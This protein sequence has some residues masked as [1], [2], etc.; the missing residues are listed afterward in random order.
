MN[1]FL[2]GAAAA[3]TLLSVNAANAQTS[4]QSGPAATSNEKMAPAKA[5][6]K[7]AP[8]T[9]G[10]SADTRSDTSAKAQYDA[11]PT[12]GTNVNQA[13]PEGDSGVKANDHAATPKMPPN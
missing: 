10:S 9:V 3:A 12:N 11:S 2:I 13:P 7:M 5:T 4:S 6:E 8:K 1:K